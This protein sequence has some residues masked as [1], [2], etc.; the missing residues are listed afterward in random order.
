FLTRRSADLGNRRTQSTPRPPARRARGS[1]RSRAGRLSANL[2][3]RPDGRR[4]FLYIA[5]VHFQR[6]A[7]API[8]VTPTLPLHAPQ[9]DPLDEVALKH[10]EDDHNREHGQDRKS[11]V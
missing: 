6:S 10:H 5:I 4:S 7:A 11:F 9:H 3:F 2:S 8:P 1:A